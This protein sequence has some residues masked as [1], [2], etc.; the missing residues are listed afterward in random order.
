ME[1]E[2]ERQERWW[3]WDFATDNNQVATI[4]KEKTA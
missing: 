2:C 3:Q 1:G 4:T